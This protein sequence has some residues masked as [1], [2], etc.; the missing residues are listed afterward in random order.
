MRNAWIGLALL[1]AVT[2]VLASA[3]VWRSAAEAQQPADPRLVRPAAGGAGDLVTLAIPAADGRQQVVVIDPRQ[4][5]MGVY[6]I[7]STT[8]EIALRSVRQIGF[9]LQMEEYNVGNPS[10]REIRSLLS[11]R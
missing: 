7:D 10:P 9:D 1:T 8:G 5:V 4:R 11:P 2:V 6:Q 3:L